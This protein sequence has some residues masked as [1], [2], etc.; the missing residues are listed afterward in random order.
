MLMSSDFLRFVTRLAASQTDS[1]LV[2]RMDSHFL[3]FDKSK[4]F[5]SITKFNTFE[6]YVDIKVA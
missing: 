5:A 2:I 1:T 6:A 4:S 3:E